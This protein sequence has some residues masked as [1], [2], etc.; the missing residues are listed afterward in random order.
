MRRAPLSLLLPLLAVTSCQAEKKPLTGFDHQPPGTLL[1]QGDGTGGGLNIVPVFALADE[2]LAVADQRQQPFRTRLSSGQSW[3][4]TPIALSSC[5]G[6][7]SS[8][9]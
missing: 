2:H 3:G 9:S 1:L 8:G 5:T 4:K 6:Y 7:G